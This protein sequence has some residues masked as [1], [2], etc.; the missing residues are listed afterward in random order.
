MFGIEVPKPVHRTQEAARLE[1]LRVLDVL[2]DEPIPEL[3]AITRLAALTF[4]LPIALVSLVGEDRQTFAS[5]YGLEVPGTDRKSSFCA[6]ALAS[7]EVMVVPDATADPRFASN[8]LVLGAPWIRFYAGAPLIL[9]DGHCIGTLCIIDRVERAPLTDRE[10]C[11]LKLMAEQVVRVLS[12]H[13]SRK[14]QRILQ[15]LAE[16]TTDAFVCSDTDSRIVLWNRA[17]EAMFGWRA[18]EA[19]GA[20]LDLII[21]DRHRVAHNAGM[22]RLKARG[23]AKLVGRTVE[24][25]ARCKAGHELPVELS[26]TMW[27]NV[28]SPEGFAAI[29]RDVSARRLEERERAETEAKLAQQVAA[30]EASDDGIALTDADGK[31]AFMNRAHSQMFGYPD[32]SALIGCPWTVLYDPPEAKRIEM[33]AFP[34]VAEK[35]QWRG[36]T[37]GRRRDGSPM[38]QEIALSRGPDGG[39]VCV[40]RNIAGRQAMEREKIRLR[41]QL[42]L[43][44]RQ[45]AVGQLAMGIA[46]DFNN[47]IAAIS[48]TGELLLG[49]EDNRV[50]NHALRICSAADTAARLTEKLLTLS[51]RVPDYKSVDIHRTVRDACNLVV[52]S[53]TYPGHSI[54]CE[55]S[56][57]PLIA[58]ADET[59]LTQVVLNLVVNARDALSPGSPGKISVGVYT[60]KTY[61]A[62]GRLMLGS[63]P[64]E[65]SAI[66]RV[67]DNGCGIYSETLERI[68]DPFFSKKSHTGHGGSGL[69]L[70]VVAGILSS[71]GGAIAVK[72]DMGRGTVFEV[73]WPLEVPQTTP[74]SQL[75][76]AVL[77]D[78]MLEGK[79]VLVVDDNQ[80]VLETL[81]DMLEEA[82]AEVGPC[83]TPSDAIEALTEDRG[84]WDLLLSDFDMPQMNGAQLATAARKIRP[85]LPIL[86]L[87]ALP[88]VGHLD[89]D[90]V[91]LFDGILSKPVSTERLADAAVQAITMAATRGKSCAS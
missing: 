11:V 43:A 37:L 74:L 15:L 78:R 75:P 41:E 81:T 88:R 66:L 48:G 1:S 33:T 68:F 62:C 44:Q 70:A 35:G 51:R 9:G 82:G 24:V 19:I 58:V 65:P 39:I 4:D 5:R 22:G 30:I 2:Q 3:D 7:S 38:A 21:P 6:H 61:Q 63:I 47:L 54:E 46:H 8:P 23:T 56:D 55:F 77:P 13:R 73:W 32:P 86:L 60:E 71:N 29:I 45:E 90:Q 10:E 34:M 87:S 72:S 85:D 52:P 31:F 12:S 14:Q 76:R 17:A 27:S 80:P 84:S 25:P 16:T 64:K 36:E 89:K 42:M 67:S 40:T 57:T 69:G 53:L 49:I 26:L 59:E 83:L 91:A 50:R 79:T 18:E 20:S 28:S